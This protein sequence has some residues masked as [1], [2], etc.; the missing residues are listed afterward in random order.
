MIK[1]LK[2]FQ[3]FGRFYMLWFYEINSLGDHF[4]NAVTELIK[5]LDKKLCA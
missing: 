4:Y 1:N 3:K 2:E 5:V